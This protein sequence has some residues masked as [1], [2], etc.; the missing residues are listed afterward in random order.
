MLAACN[1]VSFICYKLEFTSDASGK[2][3]DRREGYVIL[4]R[5]QAR[6]LTASGHGQLVPYAHAPA[7]A[8]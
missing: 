5:S 8:P 7:L 2:K 4:Q 6:L 3:D 1:F